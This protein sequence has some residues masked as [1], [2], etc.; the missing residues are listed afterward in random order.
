[1]RNVRHRQR[2]APVQHKS[3][4]DKPAQHKHGWHYSA[5]SAPQSPPASPAAASALA[6]AEFSPSPPPVSSPQSAW[7]SPKPSSPLSASQSQP[8]P[9]VLAVRSP[10]APSPQ[11]Q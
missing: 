10:L 7:S 2:E 9:P 11:Y 1:M 3:D 5:R 8:Q 4:Q 6:S